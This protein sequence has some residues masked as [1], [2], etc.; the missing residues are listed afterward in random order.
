MLMAAMHLDA[1]EPGRASVAAKHA[2]NE[3]AQCAYVAEGNEQWTEE[4]R[5][6][7]AE[8]EA[9]WGYYDRVRWNVYCEPPSKDPPGKLPDGRQV[10]SA[11]EYKPPYE[12]YSLD[13]ECV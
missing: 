8:A 4:A 7:L 11:V 9:V 2:E 13:F 10:M 5:A 3:L 1:R 6:A 12:D